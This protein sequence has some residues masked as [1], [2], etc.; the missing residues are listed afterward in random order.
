MRRLDDLP[1]KLDVL[2]E[3]AVNRIQAQGEERADLAMVAL[4]W[5][6]YATQPLTVQDLQYAVARDVP[7]DWS[8]EA[9]L[10]PESLLISAC[11]GLVT[12]EG[13]EGRALSSGAT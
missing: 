1:P 13:T 5:V 8:D 10:V 2:Y 11:C 9:N 6:A 12:A 7:A 3:Q 4:K